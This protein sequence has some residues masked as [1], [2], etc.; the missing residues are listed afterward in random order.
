MCVFTGP[1]A[2]GSPCPQTNAALSGIV[3]SDSLRPCVCVSFKV[4]GVRRRGILSVRMHHQE[5]GRGLGCEDIYLT[6][7]PFTSR[8]HS[9]AA[10]QRRGF[11]TT[12]QIER[13]R[14]RD[15]ERESE[16]VGVGWVGGSTGQTAFF[17][18]TIRQNKAREPVFIQFDLVLEII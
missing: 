4:V 11:Q 1:Q 3:A 15:R 17:H 2:T 8:V 6:L 9:A 12:S 10:R 14:Q 5:E 18:H 7:P 13:V 16:G